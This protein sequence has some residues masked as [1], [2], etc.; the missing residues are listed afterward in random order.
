MVK[1]MI[2]NVVNLPSC[3]IAKYMTEIPSCIMDKYMIGIF[4]FIDLTF[5]CISQTE[6]WK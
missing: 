1:N 3:I 4:V 5:T 2:A 6:A